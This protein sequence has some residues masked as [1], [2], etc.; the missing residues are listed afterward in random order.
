MVMEISGEGNSWVLEIRKKVEGFSC[1]SFFFLNEI[2]I[3]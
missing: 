1:M 2:E 3:G